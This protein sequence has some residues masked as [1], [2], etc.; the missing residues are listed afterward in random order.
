MRELPLG[1]NI[2]E[3]NDG[4]SKRLVVLSGTGGTACKNPEKTLIL[5]R[6]A[7]NIL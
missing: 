7:N 3:G 2:S 4:I 1:P 5:N 6:I